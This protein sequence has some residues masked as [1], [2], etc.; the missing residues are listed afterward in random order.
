[1]TGDEA[2]AALRAAGDPAKA[3][4]DAAYHRT[5]RP[6]WGVPGDALAEMT[7][8]WRRSLPLEERLAVARALWADGAHDARIAA[9]KLLAQARIREDAEVWALLA[10]WV[11][12][13]D[14]WAVA[15]TVCGAIAKR[16]VAEP[17]RLD[18]V[19]G[20][21]G[22]EHLWTKRAALVATLPWTKRRHPSEAERAT[23]E[24][25]LGWAAT[26]VS[27]DRWFVQKAVAW[28]LRDLS[29]RDPARVAA[30]LDRHG[31]AMAPF[32][33]REAARLLPG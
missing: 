2:L 18:V 5:E 7:T 26:C 32:A 27:D 8:A 15:D 30:F 20:W 23:R 6:T 22:A 21:V 19:E 16:L 13:F 17:S 11:P 31:D 9:P 33:R 1:M 3:A 12:D 14:G 24:R 10:S 28:W 29:R 25:V 4:K